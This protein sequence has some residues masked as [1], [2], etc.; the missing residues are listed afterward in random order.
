MTRENAR[1]RRLIG[2]CLLAATVG[3]GVAIPA[4]AVPA[5]AASVTSQV[6]A[7]LPPDIPPPPPS[8]RTL[9]LTHY[10][11]AKSYWCGPATGAMLVKI[12]NGGKVSHYN[13]ASFTQG[14]F[15]GPDHMNTEAAGATTWGSGNFTRGVNRWLGTSYYQQV[16]APSGSTMAS[17]LRSTIGTNGRPV[18]A[19][20]VEFAGGNHYNGHPVGS[21]IGHWI[22]AYG[23]YNSGENIRFA[24]PS[25]SVWS[26]VAKTFTAD[27]STFTS[28]YLQSNGVAY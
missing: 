11:Q 27:T 12:I 6:A 19:D 8:A 21:T 4:F 25:T 9:T 28:R 7:S 14:H 2:S 13:G 10:A 20:T 5:T 17:A 26:G 18:A 16:H 15:A 1:G 24:D 3:A 23:Y 22:L